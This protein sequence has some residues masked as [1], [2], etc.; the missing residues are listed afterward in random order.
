MKDYTSDI[1]TL[2]FDSATFSEFPNLAELFMGL[3][4]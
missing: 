3:R 2:C 1:V 4:I